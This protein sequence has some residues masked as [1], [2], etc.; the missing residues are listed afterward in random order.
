MPPPTDINEVVVNEER[1]AAPCELESG[2][3]FKNGIAEYFP[4][5]FA[6]VVKDYHL[7]RICAA[8]IVGASHDLQQ[9]AF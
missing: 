2:C 6:G 5:A 9:S 8:I 3:L 7:V 1:V 4:E